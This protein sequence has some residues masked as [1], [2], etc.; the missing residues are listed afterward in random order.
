EILSS[1]TPLERMNEYSNTVLET[2]ASPVVN[3]EV[4][5]VKEH[6]SIK[7]STTVLLNT[8]IFLTVIVLFFLF[9]YFQKTNKKNKNTSTLP[10]VTTVQEKEQEIKSNLKADINDY[11]YYLKKLHQKK[12]YDLFF[13][14]V[15]E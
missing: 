2:V 15:E 8:L 7:W 5:K 9:R 4:L 3:T 11:F 14:T 12:D 13:Q 1:R 6:N 10:P